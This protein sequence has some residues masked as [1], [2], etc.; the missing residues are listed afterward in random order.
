MRLWYR[1]GNAVYDIVLKSYFQNFTNS[2]CIYFYERGIYRAHL[3][4]KTPNKNLPVCIFI[5]SMFC[6][7]KVV[8]Y[9]RMFHYLNNALQILLFT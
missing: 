2:F 3:A 9:M 7:K 4:N 8:C 1:N 6:Y 5:I